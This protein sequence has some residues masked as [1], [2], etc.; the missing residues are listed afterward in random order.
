MKKFMLLSFFVCCAQLMMATTCTSILNGGDWNDPSTW[1]CGRVPQNNDVIIIAAGQTIYVNCNCGVYTNFNLEI[2]GTLYFNGG[3]KIDLDANGFVQV[4][5][6][7]RVT[8]DNG[9]S[10]IIIDGDAKWRGSDPDI[11]GP[12][13]LDADNPGPVPGLL[14][15]ELV[16]FETK[17][18]GSNVEINWAT[19]SELDNAFFS[20]E[21]STDGIT[22]TSLATI[23]GAGT[24]VS[25]LHYTY[26]D[27]NAEFGTSYYRLRQTD[28]DGTSTLSLTQAV[29]NKNQSTLKI[30]PSPASDQLTIEGIGIGKADLMLTNHLGQSMPP[31][32][33]KTANK[34]FVDLADVEAGIYFVS[35]NYNGAV[36]SY[37]I[38]V[39]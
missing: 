6:G 20:I 8:G 12:S 25:T 39:R 21:R 35:L 30:Y 5:A 7:G 16:Y 1:D 31:I 33:N 11:I 2:Y 32:C 36:K 26:T 9:G 24:S 4:H 17:L 22:W 3:Q 18:V 38:I 27:E 34:I 28:F 10:K 15:I 29:E 19:A 23:D 14:P 13:Y 37:K